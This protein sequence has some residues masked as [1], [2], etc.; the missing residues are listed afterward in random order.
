M[1]VAVTVLGLQ[2]YLMG[3]IAHEIQFQALSN[4][5]LVN[6]QCSIA[7]NYLQ[8][9]LIVMLSLLCYVCFADFVTLTLLF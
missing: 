8:K 5:I 2:Y 1:V 6:V 7:V 4:G 9:C 3:S